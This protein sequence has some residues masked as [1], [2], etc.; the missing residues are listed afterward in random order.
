[1]F[2]MFKNLVGSKSLTIQD[3]EPALEKMKDH[4]IGKLTLT[5]DLTSRSSTVS[6]NYSYISFVDEQ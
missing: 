3:L 4:L 1:M 2:H 5:F 6:C